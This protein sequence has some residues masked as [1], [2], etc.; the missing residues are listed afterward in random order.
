MVTCRVSFKEVSFK[1]GL[2]LVKAVYLVTDYECGT[3]SRVTNIDRI[4][5]NT[6]MVLVAAVGYF[7][8]LWC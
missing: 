8:L 4:L 3:V 6:F 1:D 7:A 2:L 5:A